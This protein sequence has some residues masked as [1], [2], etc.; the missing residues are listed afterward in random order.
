[1]EKLNIAIIGQGRSGRNIHGAFYRGKENDFINVK[2]V[3]ELDKDRR[4]RALK[5]YPGCEVMS[6]WKELI[7]RDDI[8]LVV[9]ASF[10]NMHYDITKELLLAGFNV[11]VEKPFARTY[12]FAPTSEISV[13]GLWSLST[14]ITVF[15]PAAVGF[16]NL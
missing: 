10:S 1:M 15:L 5:E 2:L 7:G 4:E 11:L 13:T 6:D 16:S 3:V 9:N 12:K 14:S 8:Q